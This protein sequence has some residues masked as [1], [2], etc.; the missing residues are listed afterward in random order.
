MPL[1]KCKAQKDCPGHRS[2]M[3]QNY[4]SDSDLSS[5]FFVCFL[6]PHSQHMEVPRLG[7]Q[8]ELQ[9]R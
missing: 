7:V 6:G 2:G 1:Y 8:S 4:K 3:W 5:F 9:Q